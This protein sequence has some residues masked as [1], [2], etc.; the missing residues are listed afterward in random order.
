MPLGTH[1]HN[2]ELKIG[3]GGQMVR[4]AGTYA[5]LMAKE[6]ATPH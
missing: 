5:Q 2:V 3:G 4:S 1:V 6:A